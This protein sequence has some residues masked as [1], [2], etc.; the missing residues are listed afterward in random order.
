MIELYSTDPVTL[1]NPMT[2]EEAI[3]FPIARRVDRGNGPEALTD[4]E[5]AMIPTEEQI[6]ESIA[7]RD[8]AE[9]R[10]NQAKAAFQAMYSATEALREWTYEAKAFWY[11]GGA[12]GSFDP[13]AFVAMFDTVENA[14]LAYNSLEEDQ[15]TFTIVQEQQ[16]M[17]IRATGAKVIFDLC[18]EMTA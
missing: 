17:T 14:G 7:R 12:Y 2:G 8:S 15:L 5:E 3:Y 16:G 4:F 18:R 11:T 9:A 13:A 10:G 1:E 6:A